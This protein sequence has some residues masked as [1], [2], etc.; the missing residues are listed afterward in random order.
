[1][2]STLVSTDTGLEQKI[3]LSASASRASVLSVSAL[4]SAPG[5]KH[6]EERK[7]NSGEKI[8]VCSERTRER[9]S[10]LHRKKMIWLMTV[11]KES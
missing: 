8:P 2:E 9:N 6:F 4:W 10:G 3:L 5:D 11:S 7:R 1:M